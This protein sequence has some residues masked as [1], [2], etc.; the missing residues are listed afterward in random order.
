VEVAEIVL[1]VNE[2]SARDFIWCNAMMRRGQPMDDFNTT[3]GTIEPD[4]DILTYTASDEAIEAAAG[5]EKGG[6]FIVTTPWG[7][8]N[9]GDWHL[10]CCGSDRIPG[11]PRF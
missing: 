10:L 1:R 8:T 11:G 4:E 7:I 5:I 6:V 3:T 2:I 9:N